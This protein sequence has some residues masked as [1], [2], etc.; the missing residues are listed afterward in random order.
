[1]VVCNNYSSYD[2]WK[3]EFSFFSQM[4]MMSKLSIILLIIAIVELIV[5][6]VLA[7]SLGKYRQA[8][9]KLPGKA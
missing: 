4:K 6:I 8:Y 3:H 5:V 1:M 2:V 7:V 9:G